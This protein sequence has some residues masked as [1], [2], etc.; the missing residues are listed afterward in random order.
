MMIADP[1]AAMNDPTM[2]LVAAAA[3]ELRGLRLL[4]VT[5]T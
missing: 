5:P 3:L 4:R 1:S 2:L